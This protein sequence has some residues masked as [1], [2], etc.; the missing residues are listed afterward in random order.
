MHVVPRGRP[1]VRRLTNAH[2]PTE[3]SL[4]GGL[5]FETLTVVRILDYLFPHAETPAPLL[6]LLIKTV[7]DAALS[8]V[9]RDRNRKPTCDLNQ[10][11]RQMVTQLMRTRIIVRYLHT[12]T[13]RMS[14]DRARYE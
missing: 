10:Q 3:E 7:Y 8:H 9:G 2:V 6:F 13:K 4:S 12:I 11:V 1:L 5:P 14:G